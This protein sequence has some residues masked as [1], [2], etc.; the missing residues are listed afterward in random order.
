M[1]RTG[2][3]IEL[4]GLTKRYGSVEAV[5][6]IDVRIP[7]DSYCC[8]LGPS[9]CG[10]T[11]T[12]RMIA[13]HESVSEGDILIGGA[14]VSDLM[15]A[16]RGTAM[17]FQSYALFP[18]LNC[19][20][21]VAFSLKMRGMGK[22]ERRETA[23]EYLALVEM[24]QHAERLPSQLSGGQQQRVALARALVTKPDVLLLDEPLSALDPF[25][26]IRMREEL[27]RLQSELGISFI[28][29]THSQ[30]EAMALADLVVVMNDGRIEQAAPPREVF[31]KPASVFVARFIGG[32]NVMSGAIAGEDPA[33][34]VAIRADRVSLSR[35]GG[36]IGDGS[37]SVEA[38]IAAIE[39]LGLWAKLR[40]D[41][42]ELQDFTVSLPDSQFFAEGFRVGESVTASWR[43]TD[44]HRLSADR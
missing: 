32:H 38:K 25:L 40:L 5:K 27:K 19:A 17:M 42:P 9:G 44:L 43:S 34:S 7:E 21:N 8:L 18:H 1:V 2:G 39:Y 12:L 37:H 4:V 36:A 29:V 16:K 14:N 33:S 3:E 26:R 13:G 35:A 10:K 30:E 31:E 23:M 20:E 6:A 15:P 24:D 22:S 28:H 41:A 11:T